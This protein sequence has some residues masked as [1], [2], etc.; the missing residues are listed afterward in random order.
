MSAIEIILLA[1]ALGVDCCVVSFSQGLVVKE[2]K[3]LNS[4][5]FAF[6]MG[7]FQALMP[8]IGYLFAF[9]ISSLVSNYTHLLIFAIFLI[10]GIN[11]IIESFVEETEEK[12]NCIDAKCLLLLGV[13]TSIDALGAGA[14]L[15]FSETTLA[16]PALVIG[17]VSFVMSLSGFWFSEFFKNFPSKFMEVTGGLI[18]I[19][20][21]VKA[22]F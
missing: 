12:N 20:L 9:L 13:A 7:L 11:C 5:K 4:L 21:A 17:A 14:S 2:E 15:S 10:L 16:L 3:E 19:A 22:L 1:I 6:T 8:A 18:L